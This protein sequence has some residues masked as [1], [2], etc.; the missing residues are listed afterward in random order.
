MITYFVTKLRKG[1]VTMPVTTVPTQY[2]YRSQVVSPL[3]AAEAQAWFGDIKRI[4]GTKTT[5]C[6][7]IDLRKTAVHPSD[8]SKVIEQ[9]MKWNAANGLQRSAVVMT[10]PIRKMGLSRMTRETASQRKERFFAPPSGANWEKRELPWLGR[11]VAPD[12]P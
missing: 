12:K 7:L 3:T 10:G 8:T 6:Q 11:G 2:G 9:I 4:A 5:Y 1:E